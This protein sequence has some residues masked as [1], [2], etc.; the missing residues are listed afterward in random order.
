MSDAAAIE[1]SV[2]L[3]CLDEER[4]VAGCIEAARRCLTDAGVAHEVIVA[5]NG[6]TD[7]TAEIAEAAGARVVHITR[8]GYGAAIMGGVE[9][10]RGDIVVYADADGSY[11]LHDLMP[12]VE[13]ARSGDELVVGDRY[14]GGIATGAMPFL[15]R[16]LGT[17]VLS[18]V[19]RRLS[20]A[21]LRDVN[22]GLRAARRD[23]FLGLG[24]RRDG[25]DMS[26]ETLMRAARAGLRMSEVPTPLAP[27]GRDRP[28]HLRTW[29]DG[30]R[31]LRAMIAVALERER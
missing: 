21:S 23:R 27:D 7:R 28:P 3:P 29:S 22:C 12:F 26:V 13:R 19:Y 6:S 1:V 20:G 30:L 15:H 14:A 17:P 4:T 25:F 16:W 18:W 11:A 5:D 2:V 24:I 8:R 9:A 10:A 31:L